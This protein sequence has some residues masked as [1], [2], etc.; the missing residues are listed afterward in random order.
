MRVGREPC[1]PYPGACS[2][3]TGE[4]R[5]SICRRAR[6]ANGLRQKAHILV[7]CEGDYEE[8]PEDVNLATKRACNHRCKRCKP[9]GSSRQSMDGAHC[10]GCDLRQT[11]EVELVGR[12]GRTVVMAIA[13]E[14]RVRQH[15]AAVSLFPE[16]P[17][18]R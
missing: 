2:D 9:R 13:Q 7:G 11:L 17:L 12:V 18:V 1:N 6:R 4:L 15:H 5:M 10:A 14:G 3:W 16:R 8:L